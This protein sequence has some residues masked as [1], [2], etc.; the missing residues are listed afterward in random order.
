MIEMPILH[1]KKTK[2]N[3]DKSRESFSKNATGLPKYWP[4]GL[5]PPRC[6]FQISA[7]K[8]TKNMKNMYKNRGGKRL[9]FF[10]H[11]SCQ[12]LM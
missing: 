7:P 6:G 10:A 1:V 3:L 9:T 5:K 12:N 8:V 11:F 4:I 2:L